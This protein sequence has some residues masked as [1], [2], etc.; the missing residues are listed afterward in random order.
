MYWVEVAGPGTV[1]VTVVNTVVTTVVSE[2]VVTV[3]GAV[4]VTVVTDV[5]VASVVTVTGGSAGGGGGSGGK[6]TPARAVAALCVPIPRAA[7]KSTVSS[8]T[9]SNTAATA[10]TLRRNFAML[11]LQSSQANSPLCVKSL[12][13]K[14]LLAAKK[15]DYPVIFSVPCCNLRPSSLG[16]RRCSRRIRLAQCISHV[17]AKTSPRRHDVTSEFRRAPK[18]AEGTAPMNRPRYPIRESRWVG[19][20][21]GRFKICRRPGIYPVQSRYHSNAQPSPSDDLRVHI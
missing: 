9:A 4:A 15:F 12:V 6:P 14:T 11:N 13:C 2:V 10:G 5:W 18:W 21:A 20:E 3:V 8:P 1:V 17:D 7:P 19:F 16:I